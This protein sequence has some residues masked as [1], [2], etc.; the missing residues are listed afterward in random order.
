M[1]YMDNASTTVVDKEAFDMAKKYLFENYANPSSSY[2]M[3][4]DVKADMEDAR[5]MIADILGARYNEI[6]FTSGGSESNNWAILKSCELMENKGK[7][8]ISSKI[9][10]HSVLHTLSYLE[11]KGY[12][13]T[14]LSTDEKGIIDIN[15]LKSAI[16]EDT[17]LISIMFANNE[18]GTIEPIKEIGKIAREHNILFHTDAV[19][20]VGHL[21]IDVNELNIDLLSASGHKFHSPKGVGFLYIRSGIKLTSLIHGGSQERNRR[22]GTEN[23]FGIVAMANAMKNCYE[24]LKEYNIQMQT[25]RDELL[26]LI[27]KN[28]EGSH[29]NG[30]MHN[31]L[32]N[33]INIYFE[34]INGEL[35]LILLN[36]NGVCASLGSACTTGSIDPS[37][38]IMAI[39]NDKKRASSSLRLTLSKYTTKDEVNTTFEVLKKCI[40][41]LRK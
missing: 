17:V 36:Q 1:I 12:E 15:E 40:N 37:H 20:A 31:R 38:V 2:S 16:R 4:N 32:S 8:I 26:S 9:E 35:L 30:C 29:L 11:K 22:A 25:L 13:V 19:Q 39:S 18:I 21:P 34:N 33:N 24:H 10:H 41:Q 6:Y 27:L 5:D 28:I 3:A 14:Y 23:T 7:H